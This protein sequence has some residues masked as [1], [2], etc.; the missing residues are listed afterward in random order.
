M[1]NVTEIQR[2]VS[3][4][5]K[6]EAGSSLVEVIIALL[7]L[8][9]A[10]L[11]V[12]GVFAYA[13]QL[14][15]GNSNRSQAL[16]VLQKEVELL[17]SAKFTPAVVSNSTTATPTCATADDG[18]RDVTGGIK[19]TQRRCGADGTVYF[20]ET[21][22]D[23]DPFAAGTQ[24]NAALTMKEITLTVTP[25]GANGTWITAYRTRAVFRRVRAN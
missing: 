12:L 23:D 14:N 4:K 2:I 11:G 20:V 17:R 19:A 5:R 24:V 10:V 1:S 25:I 9:I 15:T 16:S 21:T 6:T 13:T 22:I 18:G 8:T 7:I 3:S